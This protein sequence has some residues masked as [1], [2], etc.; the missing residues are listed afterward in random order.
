[1]MDDR[2]RREG[3]HLAK[4]GDPVARRSAGVPAPSIEG[5]R[6]ME[7]PERQRLDRQVQERRAAAQLGEAHEA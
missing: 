4:R 2:E 5:E 1:M 7:I 3:V 6:D